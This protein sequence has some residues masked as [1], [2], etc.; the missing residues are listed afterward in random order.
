MIVRKHAEIDSLLPHLDETWLDFPKQDCVHFHF[1][2]HI[3]LH[4]LVDVL[5]G[6]VFF[7]SMVIFFFAD[8]QALLRCPAVCPTLSSS[9]RKE[10]FKNTGEISV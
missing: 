7:F 10:Y 5:V 4:L 6:R 2:I 3:H 8:V 1:F 9:G